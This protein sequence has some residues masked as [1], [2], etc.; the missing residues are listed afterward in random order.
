MNAK[1]LL[2]QLSALLLGASGLSLAAAG[3]GGNTYPKAQPETHGKGDSGMGGLMGH[4]A[5]GGDMA[6]VR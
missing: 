1:F 5:K 3:G 4:G 6:P 2:F